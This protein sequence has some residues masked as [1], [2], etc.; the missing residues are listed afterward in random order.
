MEEG[1]TPYQ[2]CNC[3]C[4]FTKQLLQGRGNK[5]SHPRE[6]D[7]KPRK[8]ADVR[9]RDDSMG[10][11]TAKNSARDGRSTEEQQTRVPVH[12]EKDI[13]HRRERVR[14]TG[15]KKRKKEKRAS[16]LNFHVHSKT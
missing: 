4:R 5:S 2:N 10:I 8:Q 14:E 6:R 7:L 16:V 9:K 11:T 3:I 13:I 15:R 12:L 1:K